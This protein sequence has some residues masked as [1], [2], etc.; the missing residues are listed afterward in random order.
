MKLFYLLNLAA[1]A[2]AAPKSSQD[3]SLS[4]VFDGIDTSDPINQKIWNDAVNYREVDAIETRSIEVG[5]EPRACDRNKLS[6]CLAVW[7]TGC[8]LGCRCASCFDRA[9]DQCYRTYPDCN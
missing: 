1:L 5:I 4:A 3:L 2:M 9:I 8:A 7:N 6:T